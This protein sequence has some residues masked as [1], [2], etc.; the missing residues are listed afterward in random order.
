M[1]SFPLPV[2]VAAGIAAT[3]LEETRRLPRQLVG[4][5]ITVASQALQLSMR[6]QQQ[7][8]ELAIKGDDTLSWCARDEQQPEWTTFDEDEPGSSTEPGSSADP[9]KAVREGSRSAEPDTAPLPLPGYDQLTLPQLR[10]TLRRLSEADLQRLLDHERTHDRRPDF[11][12]MLS[13]RI[14]TLRSK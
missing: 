7:V 5:P 3:A 1:P 6:L 10:G 8:T 11:E 13:N 4:L 9:G 2:R 12:R 14:E